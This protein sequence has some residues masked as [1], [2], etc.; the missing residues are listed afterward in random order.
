M[1]SA[2]VFE[3]NELEIENAAVSI[4]AR[5]AVY[6]DQAVEGG[7]GRRSVVVVVVARP[8]AEVFDANTNEI[9]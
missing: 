6:V 1:S 8:A 4:A 5:I 2:F 3:L 9:G 7:S